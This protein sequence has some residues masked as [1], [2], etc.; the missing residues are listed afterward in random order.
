MPRPHDKSLCYV[1]GDTRIVV[2]DRHSSLKDL[3]SRL[4]RTILNGRPFTLKYQLPDE[5]LD[6][7]IT[8]TTNEDLDNMIEEYDRI[9]AG[10][11]AAAPP[12]KLSPASRLRV[13]LFFTKPESSVSMGSLLDD[14]KSETW[15]VDALNNSGILSRGVSDSAAG[16]SILN[17]DGGSG[18]PASGSSN[19]LEAQ[20]GT[21]SLTLLDK[22]KNVSDVVQHSTPGSPMLE[23][24]SSS[25]SLSPSMANLPPIRVRVVDD[26]SGGGGGSRLQQEKRVGVVEEQFAQMTFTANDGFVVASS[27]VAMP[28]IPAAV[29]MASA[30][31]VTTTSDHVMNRV[32]SDDERSDHG[33][34]LVGSRK[35]PLPL[36]LVQPK[37]SGGV[38]LPSPD[39]VARYYH[40]VSSI[41][42]FFWFFFFS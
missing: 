28:A 32:I 12:L 10:V 19:N 22:V 36:Q 18:V 42:P 35:P 40:F 3:C 8:V 16:D 2:V 17:L 33:G 23:N 13:F 38:S 24:S 1:G 30:G 4:S 31:M 14:A 5:D 25:S 7:L 9:A 6:N 37:T 27:A 34:A 41:L 11:A 15:F 20:G 21:E 26:N 29:T 39:S